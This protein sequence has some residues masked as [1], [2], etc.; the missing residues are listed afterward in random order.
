MKP[1]SLNCTQL[2]GTKVLS[3]LNQRVINIRRFLISDTSGFFSDFQNISRTCVDTLKRK[4]LHCSN[5]V[6]RW[7]LKIKLTLQSLVVDYWTLVITLVIGHRLARKLVTTS[8]YNFICNVNLRDTTITSNINKM[9][10]TENYINYRK[11]RHQSQTNIV[12]N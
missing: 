4:E 9:Q 2:I 12:T 10:I 1:Y 8:D 5:V 6:Y 7:S 11:H 3:T